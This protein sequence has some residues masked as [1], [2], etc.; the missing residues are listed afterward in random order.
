MFQNQTC[1]NKLYKYILETFIKDNSL[2]QKLLTSFENIYFFLC[3]NCYKIQN[4]YC[5]NYLSFYFFD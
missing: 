4:G 1:I 2:F 5:C 3:F